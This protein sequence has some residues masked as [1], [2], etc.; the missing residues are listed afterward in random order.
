MTTRSTVG[1]ANRHVKR[2]Q[3]TAQAMNMQ[4]KGVYDD[5]GYIVKKQFFDSAEI[6]ALTHIVDRIHRQWLDRNHADYVGRQL[7]NMHSLTSPQYFAGRR[8]ERT[9]FFDCIAPEKLVQLMTAMFGDGVYFHNSQLFF[10][11]ADSSKRPYWHRDMQSSRID[12]AVQ[13][14]EQLNMLSLHVRIPLVSEKGVELVPGT[15]RRWD[16]ELERDVRF[17]RGGRKNSD[18]LPGAVRV[19][20]EAGDI[21]V[22]SAQMLHRGNYELNNIRK[23]LDLCV[24]K[25]HPL[26]LDFLDE[27]VLSDEQE[28]EKISSRQWYEA[29]RAIAAKK[30]IEQA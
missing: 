19:A 27:K 7:I 14:H 25:I 30:V 18:A 6:A 11:P 13:K 20:L 4:E 10:N 23:A 1:A 15:H 5:Q 3:L 9:R 29:A 24:G 2:A 17:E 28:L 21:L 22:F 12:D 16:S 26:T 8:D